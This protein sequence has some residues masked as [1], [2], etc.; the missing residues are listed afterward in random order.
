MFVCFNALIRLQILTKIFSVL[1]VLEILISNTNCN[2]PSPQKVEKISDTLYRNHSAL[3]KYVGMTTCKQCHPKI[4]ESFIKTGMGQSFGLATKQKSKGN[5]LNSKFY[6]KFSKYNYEAKFLH[7]SLTINEFQLKKHDT[8]F[9]R[10][11]QVNF[12]I[13]SGQHTN[14]HLQNNN[15][16]ITQMPMTFYVQ[17]QKWDMPPGFENGV[18]THFNRK[19]GIEC[20]LCHNGIPSFVQGSENKYNHVPMGIDCERC[21]GPGSFHVEEKQNGILV[22]TSSQIDYSIVNPAK[23]SINLQFDL[24][25]RCHLQGNAVLKNGKSFFDFKPGKK[26]SDFWTVFLPKYSNADE[27]FIMASH[28]DR[29]KQSQ[30]F[31]QSI[32]KISSNKLKPYKDALTC[33]TCH[34]PHVSVRETNQQKFNAACLNCHAKTN[35]DY[36]SN[37]IQ[38][39]NISKKNITNCVSC[40]MPASGSTDIPHVSVHDHFIRKPITVVE[41]N[42]IKKFLGLFA[43]NEKQVSAVEKATAY[44][45]QY[46]K[47]DKQNFHLDSANNLLSACK[48]TECIA[49][50]IQLNFMKQN[51]NQVIYLAENFSNIKSLSSRSLDN[52]DAWTYYRISESYNYLKK[53][54][55]AKNWMK[56]AVELAP[57][58]LEF[59][60]KL[61]SLYFGLNK[62]NLAQEEWEFILKENNKNISA[63]SNLGYL[64]LSKGQHAEAFRLFSLGLKLEPDNESLLLNLAAYYLQVQNKN[65]A[66]KFIEKVLIVNPKNI[67]A[68]Q[69]LQQLKFNG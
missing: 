25:M 48:T 2:S 14:S 31:I 4:Y 37:K 46:E 13:G 39:K 65:M 20:M 9:S 36:V 45:Q 32:K 62:I 28:A 27:D 5:F 68:T 52:K 63:Y 24:C 3:A 33:V 29:L 1:A 7:D 38:H 21:H 54:N 18:N 59:R 67:K 19:I 53:K 69:A 42:K 16:Y 57:Y 6:D 10:I 51:F 22:D 64:F 17:K 55:E 12:I 47:F 66:I 11:E 23:L 58:N 43:I 41:K 56:L 40:H 61:A 8:T 34:N 50:K 30:C 49:L 35:P 15:G 44:I 60:N 26:L